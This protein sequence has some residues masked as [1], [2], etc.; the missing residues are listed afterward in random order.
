M[1]RVIFLLTSF[2]GRIGR[3]QFWIGVALICVATVVLSMLM[4]ALGLGQST[5][6]KGVTELSTGER[7]EFIRTRNSAS[8]LGSL[9]VAVLM[10]FPTIA[11]GMKRRHDRDFSGYDVVGYVAL[12]LLIQLSQAFGILSGELTFA[13][14]IIMLIWGICL[15][16]L[17]GFLRGTTGPNTYGPDPL[18]ADR[19][20][21]Q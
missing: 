12:T 1:N 10:A 13:L 11:L 5:T 4:V 20:P 18:G 7:S 19:Q 17:L 21:P 6:V 15:F 16:I 14:S 2:N 9:I 3:Q 8:A